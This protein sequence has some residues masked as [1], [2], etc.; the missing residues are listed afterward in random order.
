MKQNRSS[1]MPTFK[2]LIFSVIIKW[3]FGFANLINEGARDSQHVEPCI[4]K[5]RRVAFL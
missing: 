3:R 5:D 4:F 1:K 2:K